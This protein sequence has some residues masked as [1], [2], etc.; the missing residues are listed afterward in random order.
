MT[1]RDVVEQVIGYQLTKLDQALAEAEALAATIDE[2]EGWTHRLDSA[3]PFIR[4]A[5]TN[6]R[7]A[8]RHRAEPY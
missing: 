2:A 6:V 3:S 8:Q 7:L 1:K 5:R 4:Q